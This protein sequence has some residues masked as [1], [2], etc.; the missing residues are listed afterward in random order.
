MRESIRGNNMN[1][2]QLGYAIA[3]VLS[4][5]PTFFL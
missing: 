3:A 5:P 2:Y 4:E 1:F